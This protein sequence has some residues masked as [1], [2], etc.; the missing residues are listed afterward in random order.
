MVAHSLHQLIRTQN[1]FSLSVYFSQEV[2][3][4][5]KNM[6]P[7]NNASDGCWWEMGA[8]C[9]AAQMGVNSTLLNYFS[10]TNGSLFISHFLQLF[11]LLCYKSSCFAQTIKNSNSDTFLRWMNS[12]D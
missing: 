8:L 9:G 6:I 7:T 2:G 11:Y 5:A 12:E 4:G 10:C 3:A 1:N